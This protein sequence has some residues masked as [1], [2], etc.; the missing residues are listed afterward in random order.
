M[1]KSSLAF[2]DDPTGSVSTNITQSSVSTLSICEEI[3]RNSSFFS[4]DGDGFIEVLA[5]VLVP[6]HGACIA[7]G[8]FRGLSLHLD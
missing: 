4:A 6:G 2:L 8:E 5:E 3:P 1:N 7:D